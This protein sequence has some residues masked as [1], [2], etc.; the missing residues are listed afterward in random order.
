MTRGA[1]E[2]ENENKNGRVENKNENEIRFSQNH[3]STSAASSD[4]HLMLAVYVA[5]DLPTRE[6][7]SWAK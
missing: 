6:C 1:S 5:V 2:N 3:F 4:I 7:V